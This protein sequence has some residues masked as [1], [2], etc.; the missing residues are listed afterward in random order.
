MIQLRLEKSVQV[1]L[2]DACV[3]SIKS[4]VYNEFYQMRTKQIARMNI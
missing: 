4:M 2:V 1:P 3:N